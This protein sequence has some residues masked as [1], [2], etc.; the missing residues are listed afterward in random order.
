MIVSGC[1]DLVSLLCS[2]ND[3][4]TSLDVSGRTSLEWM[5]CHCCDLLSSLN[6]SGCKNLKQLDCSDCQLTSLN[7]S[8]LASLEDLSCDNCQLT[9][10]NLSGLASLED[11]SCDN[12]QLTSLNV[13]G[14]T[15]LR[16][17]SCQYNKLTSLDP[18]TRLPATALCLTI[19]IP[20]RRKFRSLSKTAVRSTMQDEALHI[21]AR[22]AA[23]A[24]MMRRF[25]IAK[26]MSFS[27]TVRSCAA[28]DRPFRF[29]T[30]R[31]RPAAS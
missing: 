8:G 14:C 20:S 3:Q 16:C 1:Q 12:C 28:G 23:R 26:A 4:L 17:L 24:D 10:L 22:S 31:S 11:L 5:D 18:T 13:S 25:R 2:Y 7:L 9:S 6:L 29:S 27:K 30:V 19:S 15:A 21:M